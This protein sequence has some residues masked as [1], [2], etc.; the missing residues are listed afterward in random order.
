MIEELLRQR[1]LKGALGGSVSPTRE[2]EEIPSAG[3]GFFKNNREADMAAI[4]TCSKCGRE[5]VQI[6]G[7]G[8][9]WKCWQK[10]I[11]DGTYGS[12][13]TKAQKGLSPPPTHTGGKRG[14]GRSG[15]NCGEG[16]WH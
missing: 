4:G 7:K 10:A 6:I 13:E 15:T 1:M 2:V 11:E 5:N 8:L 3:L 12:V 16:I 9:C 14:N